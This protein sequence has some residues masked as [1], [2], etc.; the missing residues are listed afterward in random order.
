MGMS[1]EHQWVEVATGMTNT[2][3]GSNVDVFL[4]MDGLP[5]CPNMTD[6]EFRKRVLKLRD[7]AVLQVGKRITELQRWNSME[8]ARV[9]EWFGRNDGATRNRLLMGLI[10]VNGVLR[11]LKPKNFVRQSPELDR[12]LG[13]QP[14]MK[15]FGA[16]AHVCGPDTATHTICIHELFC[17]MRDRSAGA[18]SK[19][20]AII[21]EATHF[22]DTFSSG[23]HKYTITPFLPRWGQ[24]N[25]D[26]AIDN[27]DSIAGY[28]VY[29]N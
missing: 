10:A 9:A 24:E 23:D 29:E 4:S 3:P 25:P 19:L 12:Y 15:N 20:S 22:T 28:V 17:T 1:D 8:Q 11:D 2:T 21:H 6:A 7:E 18:D 13:C 14:N 26:L 5:I 16:A 27:A